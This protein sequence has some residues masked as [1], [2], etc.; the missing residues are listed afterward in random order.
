VVAEVEFPRSITF[1]A[2]VPIAIVPLLPAW[3]LTAVPLV[4]PEINVVSEPEILPIL[5]EALLA[6]PTAIGSLEPA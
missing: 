6:V 1:A 3:I 4:P 2:L 5:T